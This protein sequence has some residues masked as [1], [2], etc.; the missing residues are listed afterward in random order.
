MPYSMLLVE[1]DAA[2]L[3]TLKCVFESRGFEV[4][5]ATSASD[6]IR[7]LTHR[8]FD[9]VVTD[10]R[11]ETDTAGYGVVRMAKAQTGQPV[12]I[13]LSAFP[14][15]A[16]EWRNS[17]ADAMFLKGGGVRQMLDELERLIR[18]RCKPTSPAPDTSGKIKEEKAG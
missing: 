6:A 7:L 2:V 14:I 9:I 18:L 15:P 16:G 1:D 13:I 12:V 11:M 17:G 10:M 8:Q 3:Q 4:S 5:T